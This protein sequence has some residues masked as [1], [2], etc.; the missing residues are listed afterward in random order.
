M[1]VLAGATFWDILDLSTYLNSFFWSH[2]C[3]IAIYPDT[4]F[5]SSLFNRYNFS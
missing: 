2:F 3:D 4:S 1:E 5:P